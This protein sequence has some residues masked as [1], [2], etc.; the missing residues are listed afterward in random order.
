MARMQI[1]LPESQLTFETL[2][3]V[4][5]SDLNYGNHL[6]N[7]RML[8][9]LHE[10][11]LRYL[12]SFGFSEASVDGCAILVTDVALVFKNQSFAGD[13]LTIQVGITEVN[14]YGCDIIYRVTNRDKQQLVAEAK[15]GI[16]FF[17]LS[18]QKVTQRPDL[19]LE[20]CAPDLIE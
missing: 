6:G 18:K 2:L 11:R 5:V 9:L 12:A 1:E 8:A 14:K 3:S 20:R 7:D 19:F 15:T 10:A 17:N 13:K 4:R 16:V